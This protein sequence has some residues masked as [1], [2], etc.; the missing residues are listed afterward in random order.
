MKLLQ[1]ELARSDPKASP[2]SFEVLALVFG[3]QG[4]S[5][6]CQL[7]NVVS[8]LSS[9]LTRC[10][11][12]AEGA[13][14]GQ[15]APG[16]TAALTKLRDYR[17][18]LL[19]NYKMWCRFIGERPVQ[20]AASDENATPEDKLRAPFGVDSYGHG[21]AMEVSTPHCSY[22]QY[23]TYLHAVACALNPFQR[24]LAS[25]QLQSCKL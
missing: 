10:V 16:Y 25:P 7:H 12:S 17:D 24:C 22:C 2:N 20:L 21:A 19:C 9:R 14:Q 8:V 11:E 3:F 1:D 6:K 23:P 13:V 5:V 18:E 15:A 4:S